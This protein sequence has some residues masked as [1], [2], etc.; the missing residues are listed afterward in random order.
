MTNAPFLSAYDLL[1]GGWGEPGGRPQPEREEEIL[2]GP[3]ARRGDHRR[4]G[5]QVVKEAS[6]GGRNE[7]FESVVY[8]VVVIQ[9][10]A[11][12]SSVLHG[13]LLFGFSKKE[14]DGFVVSSEFHKKKKKHHDDYHYKGRL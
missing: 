2:Q 10:F 12:V 7:L 1:D 13:R 9:P 6:Q 11:F 4:W 14:S 5:P 3:P 8:S